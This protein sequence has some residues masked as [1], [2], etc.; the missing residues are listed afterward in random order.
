MLAPHICRPATLLAALVATPLFVASASA[1][2]VTVS[3]DGQ[4]MTFSQVS[5]AMDWVSHA[6]RSGNSYTVHATSGRYDPFDVASNATLTWGASPGFIEILGVKT[7]PYVIGGTMLFEIGGTDNSG[8]FNQSESGPNQYDTVLIDG[9][10]VIYNGTLQIALVNGF[11][12]TLG[13]TF[14]LIATSGSIQWNGSLQGPTLGNGLVW[15]VSVQPGSL[16]GDSL[17]V[18]TVVP[19][20]SA[21]CGLA[22]MLAFVRGRRRG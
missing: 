15:Q 17:F 8:V 20:P 14:Q 18:M 11:T 16:D 19:A 13:Q 6:S 7:S 21:L 12:P 4:S 2:V 3:G 10:S 9:P 22:G 5:E 1:G